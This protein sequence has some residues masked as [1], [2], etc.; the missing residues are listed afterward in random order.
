MG[1][2]IK[3]IKQ[4]LRE[5]QEQKYVVYYST[6]DEKTGKRKMK[7]LQKTNV[8]ATSIVHARK[9]ANEKL[10]KLWMA[11]ALKPRIESVELKKEQ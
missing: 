1:S 11:K 4:V 5:Q 9:V 8:S 2:L 10:K 7:D 3:I 6:I